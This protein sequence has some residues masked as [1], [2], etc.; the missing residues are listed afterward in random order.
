MKKCLVI[1][2][3][4]AAC[5]CLYGQDS[6]GR[7]SIS[8]GGHTGGTSGP[9]YWNDIE[10]KK[11][12]RK[13]ALKRYRQAG[14]LEP[15]LMAEVGNVFTVQPD[16]AP[17]SAF[18]T[19]AECQGSIAQPAKWS[20]PAATLARSAPELGA[21][22]R[23]ISVLQVSATCAFFRVQSDRFPTAVPAFATGD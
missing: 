7:V 5:T 23:R 18:Q 16:A 1:L 21:T 3:L 4:M 6:P 12:N 19:S 11:G 2:V 10:L 8:V 15:A 17:A 20:V 14:G 13:T 22:Q 9:Y